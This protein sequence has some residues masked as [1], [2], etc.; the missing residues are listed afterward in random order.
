MIFHQSTPLPDDPTTPVVVP[1]HQDRLL[2]A[3][4]AGTLAT[5]FICG[6]IALISWQ[7]ADDTTTIRNGTDLQGCR[8]LYLSRVTAANSDAIVIV[9]EGLNRVATKADLDDLIAANDDAQIRIAKTT[10][11]YRAAVK[12]SVKNPRQFLAD[13]KSLTP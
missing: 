2:K 11:D 13:C 9:L 5:I 7:S 12:L 6:C 3:V 10:D 4:L 8:A 1:H